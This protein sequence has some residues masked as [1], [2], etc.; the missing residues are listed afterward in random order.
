MVIGEGRN[1]LFFI[2]AYQY[3]IIITP[4]IIVVIITCIRPVVRRLGRCN[5]LGSVGSVVIMVGRSE[6]AMR[7]HYQ[8]SI[9]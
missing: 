5:R 2:T 6:G 9:V 3:M 1:E 4:R 7:G 8:C